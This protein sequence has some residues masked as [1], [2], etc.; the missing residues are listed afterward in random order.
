MSDSRKVRD[1]R[2]RI[3]HS[4]DLEKSGHYDYIER[5]TCGLNASRPTGLEFWSAR[6]DEPVTCV[7]CLAEEP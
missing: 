1:L 3:V 4:A 5:T 7:L 6:P 2:T